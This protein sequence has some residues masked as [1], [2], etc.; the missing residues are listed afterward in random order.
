MKNKANKEEWWGGW[1]QI[2]YIVRTFVNVTMYS[3]YNNN[4][5]NNKKDTVESISSRLNQA[6]ETTWGIEDTVDKI[7]H[8]DSKVK[9]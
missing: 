5:N 9:H 6:E 3:Q 7:S 4:N 2:W 1:I 8:S